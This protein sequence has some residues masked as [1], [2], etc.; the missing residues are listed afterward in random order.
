MTDA[1]R[2]VWRDSHRLQVAID[3]SRQCP[4]SEGAYSVGAVIVGPDDGEIL[5][6][7]SREADPYIH[8]EEAAL[9]KVDASDLRWPGRSRAADGIPPRT[10]GFWRPSGPVCGPRDTLTVFSAMCPSASRLPSP[11]DANRNEPHI[12]G[13]SSRTGVL[14]GCHILRSRPLLR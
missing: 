4:P 3:V 5:R 6:G 14:R 1:A 8:A 2:P 7:Q 10:G 13:P 9:A 12:S 11:A